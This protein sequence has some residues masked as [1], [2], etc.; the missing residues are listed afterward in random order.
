MICP[1]FPPFCCKRISGLD[2]S[3]FQVSP[4]QKQRHFSD[5]FIGMTTVGLLT[6]G[7]R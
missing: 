6:I 3:P 2:T 4:S 1:L 5:M 7:E